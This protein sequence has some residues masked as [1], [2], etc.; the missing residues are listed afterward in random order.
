LQRRAAADVDKLVDDRRHRSRRIELV[1]AG[2]TEERLDLDQVSPD[3]LS[4]G[5][6]LAVVV[7]RPALDPAQEHRLWGTEQNDGVE[8]TV[9]TALVGDGARDVQRRRAISCEEL[10]EM[11]LDPHVPVVPVAPARPARRVGIDRLEAAPGE[12]RQHRRLAGARHAG[13]ENPTH[14]KGA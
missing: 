12:L 11:F 14:D 13:H 8:V 10:R 7:A 5:R 1:R 3:Q 6:A 9:E 4:L 2:G